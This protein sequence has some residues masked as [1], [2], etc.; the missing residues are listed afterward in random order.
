VDIRKS[1]FEDFNRA[2]TKESWKT[3]RGNP[4]AAKKSAS[5]GGGEGLVE[6]PMFMVLEKPGVG[7]GF[8]GATTRMILAC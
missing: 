7:T 2:T 4:E 5:N 6:N 1:R 8:N 3:H